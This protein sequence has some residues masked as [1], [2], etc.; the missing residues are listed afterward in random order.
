[1]PYSP[2]EFHYGFSIYICILIIILINFGFAK[3][4]TRPT[5]QEAM[6]IYFFKSLVLAPLL[7]FTG[8]HHSKTHICQE[9]LYTLHFPHVFHP[10]AVRLKPRPFCLFGERKEALRLSPEMYMWGVHK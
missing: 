1:L 9:K 8:F 4:K 3:I 2:E 7:S 6:L 10:L 5:P